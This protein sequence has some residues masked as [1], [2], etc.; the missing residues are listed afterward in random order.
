MPCME[1]HNGIPLELLALSRLTSW[2]A[3]GEQQLQNAL[4]HRS[5]GLTGKKTCLTAR[6]LSG[7]LPCSPCSLSGICW[8][9]R[10]SVGKNKLLASQQRKPQ[11][12]VRDVEEV[13]RQSL[14]VGGL[15]PTS[16]FSLGKLGLHLR[17]RLHGAL[18]SGCLVSN[19]N[20]P[21]YFGQH[22]PTLCLSCPFW[23][24]EIT[25]F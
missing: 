13:G 5:P 3:L 1:K 12:P 22:L 20:S 18:E 2:R 10:A 14:R 11:G 8:E 6:N 23:K 16:D 9:T 17:C 21:T 7:S 25:A 4:P 15:L 24:A 19:P